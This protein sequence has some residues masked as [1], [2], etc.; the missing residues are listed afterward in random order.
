MTE[1]WYEKLTGPLAQK[2]QY[3]EFKASTKRLPPSY[4]QAV[5]AFERY[6]MYYGA[7]TYG[8]VST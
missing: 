2:R 6:F 7:V 8:D 3:R 5:E 1:H 4:R